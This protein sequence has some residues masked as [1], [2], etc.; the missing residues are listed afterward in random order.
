MSWDRMRPK[1]PGRRAE[2][3]GRW[4]GVHE[5]HVRRGGSPT[6]VEP[7]LSTLL[8]Y[9]FFFNVLTAEFCVCIAV[10]LS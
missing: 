5:R 2:N 1:I 6:Q 7:M 8:W 10:T 3:G 9:V 4:F